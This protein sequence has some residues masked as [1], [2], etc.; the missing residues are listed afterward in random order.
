[1]IEEFHASGPYFIVDYWKMDLKEPSFREKEHGSDVEVEAEREEDQ[2]PE[3]GPVER[4][5]GETE[6]KKTPIVKS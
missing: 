4:D 1:M 5:A 3:P 6:R 2:V